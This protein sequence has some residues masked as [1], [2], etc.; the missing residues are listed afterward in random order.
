MRKDGTPV[1]VYSSHVVLAGDG[2]A[3]E[4][5]YLDIA[6]PGLPDGTV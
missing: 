1:R 3:P 6:P 5:Y 4:L 2:E